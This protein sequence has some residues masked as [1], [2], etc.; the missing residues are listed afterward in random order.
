M[1]PG[2]GYSIPQVNHFVYAICLVLMYTNRPGRLCPS[3]QHLS[4]NAYD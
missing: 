4:I 1:T 3:T 2:L